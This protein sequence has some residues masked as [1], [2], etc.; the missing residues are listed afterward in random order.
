MLNYEDA[1]TETTY[2]S[3][4]TQN[5]V[6]FHKNRVNLRDTSPYKVKGLGPNEHVVSLK[7]LHRFIPVRAP[8]PGP[9][10]QL[11]LRFPFSVY[12]TR[13]V[14]KPFKNGSTSFLFYGFEF[15]F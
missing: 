4:F 14:T 12:E 10:G 7:M 8:D 9:R 5:P 15:T 11:I 1:T 2:V 6:K 13:S 3:G